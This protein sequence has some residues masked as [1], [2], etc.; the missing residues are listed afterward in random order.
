MYHGIGALNYTYGQERGV[1]AVFRGAG[2][3][4]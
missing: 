3:V 2:D 4:C 1:R